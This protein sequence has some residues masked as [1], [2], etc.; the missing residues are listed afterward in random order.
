MNWRVLE[1]IIETLVTPLGAVPDV[2]RRRRRLQKLACLGLVLA[3]AQGLL[4]CVSCDGHAVLHSGLHTH[5][6]TGAVVPLHGQ[7]ADH[8]EAG[9]SHCNR[10]VDIPL[11]MVVVDGRVETYRPNLLAHLN[12]A[13]CDDTP[14]WAGLEIPGGGLTSGNT[15]YFTPLSSIVLVV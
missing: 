12:D 2:K 4:L 8:P 13:G 15:S 6:H 14:E 3:L 10:C 5:D 7:Y 9:H 1:L 11:S